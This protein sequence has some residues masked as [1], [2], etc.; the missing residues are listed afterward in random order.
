MPRTLRSIAAVALVWCM[1]VTACDATPTGTKDPFGPRTIEVCPDGCSFAQLAPAL[2]QASDGDTIAMAAGAYDGGVVIDASVTL[3]GA[4][5][6]ETVIQGGGPVVTIGVY[7][8][9]DFPTVTIEGVTI[10]GGVTRSSPGARG[11]SR[12]SERGGMGR[13]D[14]IAPGAG[15]TLGATVT[16]RDSAI[17]GN[18]VAP[19]SSVDSGMATLNGKPLPYASAI[20]GGIDSWGNLTLE[21]T[22]VSGNLIGAAAKLSDPGMASDAQGGGIFSHLGDLMIVNSE[23]SHNVAAAT[24]PNGRYGEGGGILQEA[25]TLTI[26]DSVLEENTARLDA[27]MPHGVDVAA[28]PGGILVGEQVTTATI[29]GTRFVGNRAIMTNSLGDAT[30][31]AGGLN[32]LPGVDLTMRRSTISG[33]EASSATVGGS[34]GDAEADTGGGALLGTVTGTTVEGNTVT[35]ISKAG[36]ATAAIGGLMMIGTLE[37]SRVEGNHIRAV[38]HRG[39]GLGVRRRGHGRRGGAH[40]RRHDSS[41]QHR[42]GRGYTRVGPRRRDL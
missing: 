25:G 1:A 32:V 31:W 29:T 38:A 10:R 19:S 36:D 4:G 11:A 2:V 14:L 18:R 35:A 13:R 37:G 7:N 39:F 3:T 41:R 33:N 27:A 34:R 8:A 23:I 24:A 12:G 16:I 15:G 28:Q 6:G 40:V 26:T 9:E 5:P 22:T 17:T 21:R 42:H 30:A 20:G